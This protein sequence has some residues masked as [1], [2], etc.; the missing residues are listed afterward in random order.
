[1]YT[2]CPEG[3]AYEKNVKLWYWVDNCLDEVTDGTKVIVLT[4]A[5]GNIGSKRE[6]DVEW[7][8]MEILRKAHGVP[9]ECWT[10][11]IGRTIHI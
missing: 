10:T 3:V 4:D 5:N 7:D 6:Y 11:M 1:M 8:M 9:M 2:P